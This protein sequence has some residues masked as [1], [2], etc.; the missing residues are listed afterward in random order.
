MAELEEKIRK[1]IE[2][3][4]VA[5]ELA[6]QELM[7]DKKNALELESKGNELMN[8]EDYVSAIPYFETAMSM[9]E[10][11]G[12]EERAAV[13]AEQI[14]AC[15]KLAEEAKRKAAE[16]AEKQS[17]A[18]KAAEEMLDPLIP[19]ASKAVV[20]RP[21]SPA[22]WTPD[23]LRFAES[24]RDT[25]KASRYAGRGGAGSAPGGRPRRD[26]PLPGFPLSGRTGTASAAL[27]KSGETSA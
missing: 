15:K 4:K 5:Q 7:N 6:D 14:E 3:E 10:N 19:L 13:L 22:P 17:E 23:A 21:E 20:L 12:M 24:P 25:G 9:Y 2:D 18:D 11:L 8:Q 27:L 16:E 26:G 1:S